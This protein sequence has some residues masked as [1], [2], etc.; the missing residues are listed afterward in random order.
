MGRHGANRYALLIDLN[1]TQAG[2]I[3]QRNEATNLSHSKIE[4]S[5]ESL[6]ARETPYIVLG[7]Q[8]IES[9]VEIGG[10]E[11]LHGHL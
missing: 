3:A 9:F 6:P 7:S 5:N 4:N 2:N 10:F 8:K 1:A 11:K